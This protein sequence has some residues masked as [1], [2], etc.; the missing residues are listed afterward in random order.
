VAGQRLGIRSFAIVPNRA[1]L[2]TGLL[3]LVLVRPLAAQENQ[4]CFLCHGNTTL[5]E[6]R[7]D[8]ATLVV[9]QGE[10]DNSVHGARPP[11]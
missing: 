3:A 9:T 6:G 11:S 5:F 4:A 2:G 8:A 1:A 10:Y 7:T